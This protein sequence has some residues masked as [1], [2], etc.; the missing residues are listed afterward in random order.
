MRRQ[1]GGRIIDNGSIFASEPR[2][3]Q[4]AYLASKAVLVSL[5]WSKALE[6]RAF[7]VAAN[8]LRPGLM[9]V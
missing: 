6:G 5:T 4:S 9:G 2:M 7:G 8:C 3:Y 1:A